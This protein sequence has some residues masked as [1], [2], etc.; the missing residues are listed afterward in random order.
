MGKYLEALKL[1]YVDSEENSE[2]LETHTDKADGSPFVS[3]VSSTTKDIINSLSKDKLESIPF[4]D[5]EIA[6]QKIDHLKEHGDRVFVR[7]C[8]VGVY[9]SSRLEMV[10]GYLNEW[11]QGSNDETNVNKKENVGRHRANTWL[12]SKLDKSRGNYGKKR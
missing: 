6:E 3:S 12:R 5:H 2:F 8:L 9:G 11:R 7:R 1:L 10:E 4:S